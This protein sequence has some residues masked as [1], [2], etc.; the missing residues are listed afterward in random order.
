MSVS[1]DAD[2][3]RTMGWGQPSGNTT[4]SSHSIIHVS[5]GAAVSLF[6]FAVDF[7]LAA[8]GVD[9]GG[10]DFTH[11]TTRVLRVRRYESC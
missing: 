10:G 2:V 5:S 3:K 4:E 11:E 8:M 1:D 9:A 6:L 7:T